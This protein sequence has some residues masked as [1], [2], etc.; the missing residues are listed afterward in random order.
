MTFEKLQ[1]IIKENN[2][3]SNVILMS[4]SGW[5][6]WESDMDGVFYN[7]KSN[8]IIFT[9]KQHPS[10]RQY[11]DLD[12]EP[13]NPKISIEERASRLIEFYKP[14]MQGRGNEWWVKYN[15]KEKQNEQ[16]KN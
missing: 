3:P 6:C 16:T 9:Q 5:E 1:K 12:F 11:E 8:K 7:K 4:D 15:E 2:I 13:L 14:F 10:I